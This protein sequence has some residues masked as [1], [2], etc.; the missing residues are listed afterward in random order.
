MKQKKR[1]R[2]K[3]KDGKKEI[4]NSFSNIT[5]GKFKVQLILLLP[6]IFRAVKLDFYTLTTTITALFI[7]QKQRTL[8]LRF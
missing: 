1:E 8:I 3:M 7:L 2:W 6:L 4:A 5:L